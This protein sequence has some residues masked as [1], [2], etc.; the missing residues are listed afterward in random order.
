[1]VDGH[2]DSIAEGRWHWSWSLPPVILST[3]VRSSIEVVIPRFVAQMATRSW[4][5]SVASVKIV[6]NV[7]GEIQSQIQI[8]ARHRRQLTAVAQLRTRTES[9]FYTFKAQLV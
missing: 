7:R 4:R 3:H 5:I 6:V 1:M 2:T 9:V 8:H